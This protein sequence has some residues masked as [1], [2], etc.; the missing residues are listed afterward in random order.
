MP[1]GRGGA[2]GR[3]LRTV[4]QVGAVRELTDGQLLERFANGRGEPAE[5]AF[6][7]IVE[8]HGPMVLRVC[9]AVLPEAQ[10]AQDAFQATFLVLVKK[11]RSLWVRDSLGP[12]LHQVAYRT[13]SAARVAAA[14]RRRHE[15]QAARPEQAPPSPDADRERA[16][17]EEVERLPARL[18]DPVVLCDLEG[19]THEQ[20]ARHLGWPVGTVKSRLTRARRRLGER[21]HLR[22]HGPVGPFFA[23]SVPISLVNAT[24]RASIQFLGTKPALVAPAA[25][26]AREVL[27]AMFLS[28]IVKVGT[29]L[30]ALGGL[31]S[32]VGIVAGQERENALTAPRDD[33]PAGGSTAL[34]KRGPFREVLRLRGFVEASESDDVYC[35][36]EGQTTILSIVPDGARVAKGQVVCE[37]DSSGLRDKLH[38]QWIATKAAEAAHL[39]AKLTREVAEVAVKEYDDGIFPSELRRIQGEIALAESDLKRAEDRVLWS[40]KMLERGFVSPSQNASEKIQLQ[41]VRFAL[42]QAQTRRNVLEKHTRGKTAKELQSEVE[43]ARADELGKRSA[44]ELEKSREEKLRGQIDK[45]K[46]VAPADGMAI[47]GNGND[48]VAGRPAIE[49]GATVRQRQ[50]IL[51]VVDLNG[52]MRVVVRV[53]EPMIAR[54]RPSQKAR[55]TIDA[56]PDVTLNGAITAV[57]PIPDPSR[58]SDQGGKVFSTWIAIEKNHPGLRPGLTASAEIILDSREGVLTT[59]PRTIVRYDGKDFV[60]VPGPDG[61]ITWRAVTLGETG[62]G[63]VEVKAGL[64][65]GESVSLD[66]LGLKPDDPKS[67]T[68]EAEPEPSR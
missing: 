54:V 30:V 28:Q 45:C 19:R 35:Q 9:R 55:M 14:R 4:Y 62:E 41:K 33:Q 56:F 2:I 15:R 1:S 7:V 11:A 21:L 49:E 17:H 67:T 24:A 59:S 39:E 26:L 51:R 60:A 48:P 20:A 6:A 13:A 61:S 10:D 52:P 40:D 31:A 63:Q 22:G 68:P 16:L 18:R 5:L 50:L 32:G 58:P 34:V 36:I 57:A 43:K 25:I 44:W 27:R 8:R 38:N 46:L 3:A 37:L 64:T 65:E 12:W 66:P 47:H 53:P 23:T 29:V 42:E